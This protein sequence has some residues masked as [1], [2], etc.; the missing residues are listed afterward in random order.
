MLR[1]IGKNGVTGATEPG[2]RQMLARQSI[3]CINRRAAD[4]ISFGQAL[5]HG[6]SLTAPVRRCILGAEADRQVEGVEGSDF[7]HVVT[8]TVRGRPAPDESPKI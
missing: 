6:G 3:A 8:D 5:D 1:E 4:A 2:R 7:T